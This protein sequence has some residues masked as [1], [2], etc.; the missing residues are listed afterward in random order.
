[1]RGRVV[2]ACSFPRLLTHG[3]TLSPAQMVMDK[4]QKTLE[5]DVAARTDRA[6]KADASKTAAK[7][8]LDQG[9]ATHTAVK[10]TGDQWLVEAGET[11]KAALSAAL[12]AQKATEDAATTAFQTAE[13]AARKAL[14]AATGVC[15][16]V[17]VQKAALVTLDTATVTQIDSLTSKLNLCK[18]S[19]VHWRL[20]SDGQTCDS[21]CSTAGP[22]CDSTAPTTL[23][24]N[25]LVAAAMVEA[26]HSCSRYHAPRSYPGTPFVKYGSDCAPWDTNGGSVSSC[27]ENRYG[28]H[29]HPCVLAGMRRHHRFKIVPVSLNWQIVTRWARR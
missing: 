19:T 6:D 12:A 18:K 1:M 21:V 25:T 5:A 4:I 20:G 16:D 17:D 29:M 8:T 10:T 27:T 15:V 23:T 28:H 24:T 14:T 9:V 3:H 2:M 22:T 7:S 11:K 26:G 13:V